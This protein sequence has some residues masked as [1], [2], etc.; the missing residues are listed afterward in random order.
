MNTLLSTKKITAGRK[1]HGFRKKNRFI[2]ARIYFFTIF[3]AGFF[4][5][6]R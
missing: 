4:T 2:A 6:K 5:N 3:T 1:K